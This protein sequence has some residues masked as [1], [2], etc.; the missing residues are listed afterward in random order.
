MGPKEIL[1]EREEQTTEKKKKLHRKAEI[2]PTQVGTAAAGLFFR[3]SE[4][5]IYGAQCAGG[6]KFAQTADGPVAVAVVVAV[7]VAAAV[8]SARKKMLLL[9]RHLLSDPL[10]PLLFTQPTDLSCIVFSRIIKNSCQKFFLHF[11]RLSSFLCQES[12]S[13]EEQKAK[14]SFSV[15]SGRVQKNSS[16]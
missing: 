4:Q 2:L 7:V 8:W 16:G 1:A 10:L 12:R 3:A 11:F 15:D 13:V 9:P 5:M 14:K 6:K